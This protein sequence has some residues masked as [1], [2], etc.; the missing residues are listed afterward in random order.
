[1]AE[2]VKPVPLADIIAER[3]L[4]LPKHEALAELPA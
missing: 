3:I 4:N 1:M 2:K